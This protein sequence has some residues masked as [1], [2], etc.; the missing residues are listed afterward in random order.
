MAKSEHGVVGPFEHIFVQIA[1]HGDG[2]DHIDMDVTVQF[3]NEFWDVWGDPA[4][5]LGQ[6]FVV[7]PAIIID[8]SLWC[9]WVGKAINARI[10][11]ATTADLTCEMVMSMHHKLFHFGCKLG[12]IFQDLC[13]DYTVNQVKGHIFF[14]LYSTMR[15]ENEVR[16]GCGP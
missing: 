5:A 8:P 9:D 11:F 2:E 15:V 14:Q 1:E 10:A 7:N 16:L 12:I 6:S 13:H 3:V 4:L